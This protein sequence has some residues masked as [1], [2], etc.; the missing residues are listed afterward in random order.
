M[1]TRIFIKDIVRFCALKSLKKAL[2]YVSMFNIFKK[3]FGKHSDELQFSYEEKKYSFGVKVL[4]ALLTLIILVLS[5]RAIADL[6]EGIP[7]I[8]YPNLYDLQENRDVQHYQRT[9]LQPLYQKRN[10]LQHKEKTVRSEYDTSLLE[11]IADED[12]RIYGNQDVVR[13]SFKDTQKELQLLTTKI[14]V[15]EEEI[16]RLKVI[17]RAAEKPL[18]D[19]YRSAVRIRQLKVFLWEAIF[20]IPFFFI[21]LW[22]Y[23]RTKRKNSRWEVIAIAAL[24][25]SSVITLQSFCIFLWSWIPR[26]LLEKLW[27][28]L[29]ATLLTRIVGYYLMMA[30]IVLLLGGLIVSVHRR[31]T[32]P[33]RGGKKKI[34]NMQCPTCSYPLDLSEDY[35]GG[36]GK[37]LKDTCASCGKTNCT[38]AAV[39]EH[40][41]KKKNSN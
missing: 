15:G 30:V 12:T 18:R 13:D 8:Q 38:W 24:I 28:I 1:A 6:Q 34:R 11:K 36:C 27:E 5:E 41:G 22:W 3:L 7:R 29:Q 16:K 10:D 17:A 2:E 31:A 33:V 26:E 25:A 20:W 19:Q 9:V 4:V 14:T 37:Q 39:C 21:T 32:D 23:S 40:C 35:C